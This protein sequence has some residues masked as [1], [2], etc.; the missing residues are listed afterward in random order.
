LQHALCKMCRN[1]T[2][3]KPQSNL[4]DGVRRLPYAAIDGSWLGFVGAI[5]TTDASGVATDMVLDL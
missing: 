2:D 5:E 1:G 4:L 3:R